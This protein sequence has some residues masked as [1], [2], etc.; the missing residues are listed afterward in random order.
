M[1]NVGAAGAAS[2]SSDHYSR[3]QVWRE[4]TQRW[5]TA[6]KNGKWMSTEAGTV[7]RSGQK[8]KT[9]EQIKKRK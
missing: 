9:L 7:L 4:T 2:I 8:G 1:S 3:S 5:G 6:K